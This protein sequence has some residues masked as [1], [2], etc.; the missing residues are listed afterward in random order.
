MSTERDARARSLID[1]EA[2]ERIIKRAAELQ[3]QER[4][5]G[6]GL[7][8]DQ[9]LALG[10]D[11]GIP[12]RYLQ[13]A[14]IDEETHPGGQTPGLLGWLGGPA[15]LDAARVVPGEHHALERAIAGALEQ[16][17]LL[18]LKRRYADYTTWEPKGGAFA[19]LQRAFGASGKR[20][21]LARAAEVVV[22]VTPLEPG[23]CHVRLHA[24]VSNLRRQRLAGAATLFGFGALATLLAP[25]L[26]VLAPWIL[27][28]SAIGA[29]IGLA[30]AR[31]QARESERVHVELEQQLDRLEQGADAPARETK[32][33]GF[34]TLGKLADE[35]RGLIDPGATPRGQR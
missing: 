26:G 10:K 28:P 11:V 34:A 8:R 25:V 35:L 9:V 2:L 23:Y 5:I 20:F 30:H 32:G 33:S 3:A 19:S 29:L 13:Q 31:G 15:T 17:E 6:D 14:L 21:A 27:L 22:Q 18:Q 12:T 1:R 24:D 16:E 4:D 7:T